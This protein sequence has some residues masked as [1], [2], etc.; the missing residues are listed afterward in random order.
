MEEENINLLN[1]NFVDELLSKQ[2]QLQSI[3]KRGRIFGQ[4]NEMWPI[5]V[6]YHFCPLSVR[7]AVHRNEKQNW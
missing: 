7:L 4:N 6:D 5:N 1:Q 3:M 2:N